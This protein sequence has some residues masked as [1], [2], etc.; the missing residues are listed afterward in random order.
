MNKYEIEQIAK[1]IQSG[2]TSVAFSIT[3]NAVSGEDATGGHVASLTEAV[4]GMTAALV[5]ISDAINNVSVSIDEFTLV[6]RED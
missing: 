4:M 3:A 1:A 5:Q 2:L 6:T